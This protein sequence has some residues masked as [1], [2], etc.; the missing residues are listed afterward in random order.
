MLL[1]ALLAV[2]LGFLVYRWLA[3]RTGRD[4]RIGAFAGEV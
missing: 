1:A 2:V 3:R 4:T